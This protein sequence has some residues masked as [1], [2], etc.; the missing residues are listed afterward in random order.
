MAGNGDFQLAGYLE[1]LGVQGI[2]KVINDIKVGLSAVPAINLGDGFEKA[3]KGAKQVQVETAK[4]SKEIAYAATS[5]Q[6]FGDKAALALRRFTAFSIAA[7][8]TYGGLRAFFG[9]LRDASKF[10]RELIKVQ[11]VTNA[12]AASINSLR[13]EIAKLGSSLA[14]PAAELVDVSRILSQAGLSV[15]QVKTLLEGIARTRLASTFGDVQSTTEG[16]I[17]IMGQFKVP[18]TEV[19]SSLALINSAS[20]KFAVESEDLIS[21]V[22]RAGGAFSAASSGIVEG[23]EALAQFNAL[24][25]AVRQTTRQAPENIATGLRTVIGR[26]QRPTTIK[27]LEDQGVNLRDQ[28][29]NFIGVYNAIQKIGQAYEHVN[30][31][32][33]EF[34]KTIE[35]IG[36]A[37]QYGV[38]VP[39]IREF[40]LQNEILNKSLA[41]QKNFLRDTE[42]PLATL[43]EK[44]KLLAN[45][46]ANFTRNVFNS[47]VFQFLANGALE[48]ANSLVKVLDSLSGIVPLL[49]LVAG[50]KLATAFYQEGVAGVV[51]HRLL[52]GSGKPGV[53]H[54]ASGGFVPGVGYG[55]KIHILAEPG[56]FIIRKN[57]AKA[58]G[59][60]RL[61]EL[62]NIDKYAMGGFV[63]HKLPMYQDG[64][65][66]GIDFASD[67]EFND[68]RKEFRNLAKS[69][70]LSSEQ[71][72]TLA[73]EVRIIARTIPEA[74]QLFAGGIQAAQ[75]RGG[76][77]Y[78]FTGATE[79]PNYQQLETLVRIEQVKKSRNRQRILSQVPTSVVN[80]NR[81]YI[82]EYAR[83]LELEA[84]I[85]LPS[86]PVGRDLRSLT[87]QNVGLGP[88]L[89]PLQ[90]IRQPGGNRLT[91]SPAAPSYIPI[92]D[93]GY[94]IS[95]QFDALN[96]YFRDKYNY[97]SLR[98][99]KLGISQTVALSTT[100]INQ[101]LG[102]GP[103]GAPPLSPFFSGPGGRI[104]RGLNK[105]GFNKSA[106]SAQGLGIAAIAAETILPK[107][108]LSE[109]VSSG[110]SGALGGASLGFLAGGVPGAV[111]GGAY[112]GISG[113]VNASHEE[114]LQKAQ[115]DLADSSKDLEK[116]FKDL[117]SG[118][119]KNLSNLLSKRFDISENLRKIED[120]GFLS[121]AAAAIGASSNKSL[122]LNGNT[123]AGG[124]GL[125]IAGLAGAGGIAALPVAAAGI[126]AGVGVYQGGKAI[127]RALTGYEYGPQKKGTGRFIEDSSTGNI[128]YDLGTRLIGD[129]E[130]NIREAAKKTAE[131]N[132]EVAEQSREAVKRLLRAGRGRELF[133][134]YDKNDAITNNLLRGIVSDRA[135]LLTGNARG[136]I[137]NARSEILPQIA[138]EIRRELNF[139]EVLKEIDTFQNKLATASSQLDVFGIALNNS[140]NA[141]DTAFNV[142]QGNYGTNK[143]FNN[144]FKA[145]EGLSQN[146]IQQS[147]GGLESFI[148]RGL[149]PDISK[150]LL[151]L[152]S[153]NRLD[154][155]INDE[156]KKFNNQ[157]AIDNTVFSSVGGFGGALGNINQ[158][159]LDTG[160]SGAFQDIIQ[161]ILYGKGG[162]LSGLPDKLKGQI[163]GIFENLTPGQIDDFVGGRNKELLNDIK[164]IGGGTKEFA[165]K[166]QDQVN[167]LQQ[168][169]QRGAN[170]RA[171]LLSQQGNLEYNKQLAIGNRL[172]TYQQ[173]F[174]K[175]PSGQE[176]FG[177]T[178]AIKS[179]TGGT[180]NP[181]NIL[182]NIT[183]LQEEKNRLESSGLTPQNAIRLSEVNSSLSKNKQA[184]DELARSALGLSSIQQ[185]LADQERQ[186]S[187]VI[188][189]T[190]GDVLGGNR[191]ANFRAQAAIRLFESG[192]LTDVARAG[193]TPQDL[194]A[195]INRRRQ[196]LSIFGDQ[197]QVEEFNKRVIG[198]LN[199][200]G[201]QFGFLTEADAKR[202]QEIINGK[203]I[204]DS[205][206]ELLDSLRRQDEAITAQQKLLAENINNFDKVLQNGFINGIDNLRKILDNFNLPEIKIDVVHKHQIEV[207]GLDIWKRAE[208]YFVGIAE[209]VTNKMIK[210]L[211][212][213]REGNTGLEEGFAAANSL[214]KGKR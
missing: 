17:A 107:L 212:E 147:I 119:L 7:A 82:P 205:R 50:A 73:N 92:Q 8:T 18:A 185:K 134:P 195:G 2:P 103:N 55:D 187:E 35:V 182:S 159:L 125:G 117:S 11:Q 142:A 20:A 172:A 59:A 130:A 148:G 65:K 105:I 38:V 108:G 34:A 158:G 160:S 121:K 177:A 178:E 179:L 78:G 136:Q 60:D 140:V 157:G 30:P 104:T 43:E 96:P 84:A 211:T 27:F 196:E 168:L 26:L 132:K 162:A 21:A 128:G 161:N 46:W 74:K 86:G 10:E 83:D 214:S 14:A 51:G 3:S 149:G 146:Q 58:I 139:R 53:I 122:L 183:A 165:T 100:D 13:G 126:A 204:D 95:G 23:N 22:K 57:A 127:Y 72:N 152:P 131:Q 89:N 175:R 110:I 151:A 63:G 24:I 28:A 186:R 29:G 167:E 133:G 200:Q 153:L 163:S 193:L 75:Y 129:D 70:G 12:S 116:A 62:N 42:I 66:V 208:P 47:P 202:R 189:L 111:L 33:A 39:L 113:F 54:K 32:S 41:D 112:G 124:V 81:Q 171:S 61:N 207:N 4:A 80:I 77:L 19:A 67:K 120:R 145:I 176:A 114:E 190:E 138:E 56:E 69:I 170:N 88:Q 98:R 115:K 180:I 15:S 150:T 203:Q 76:G 68:I 209:Q 97:D 173:I 36:G 40:R 198:K 94:K 166:L 45:S 87:P 123:A 79:L 49:S 184:L 44:M 52:H 31:L 155:V 71:F 99:K 9:G 64:G 135:D 1:L 144:P 191:K 197:S 91:F 188:S 118:G 174:G 169:L 109:K 143:N 194:Q 106:L 101:I 156:I 37:R 154:E 5:L 85:N 90:R 210:N 137:E 164:N 199:Q 213:G 206:S 141:L 16:I 25:G 93:L 192:S 181:N 6:D 48:L 102:Q 201:G